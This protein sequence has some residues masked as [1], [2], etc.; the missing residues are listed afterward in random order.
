[1]EEFSKKAGFRRNLSIGWS[2]FWRLW[3]PL[4]TVQVVLVLTTES[5]ATIWIGIIV[6]VGI[7]LAEWAGKSVALTRYYAAIPSFIGWSIWWRG[8]VSSWILV[9]G[10]SLAN[11]IMSLT[12][13][14]WLF[15][16]LIFLC[17][18]PGSF[19]L[20]LLALGFMTNGFITNKISQQQ[21]TEKAEGIQ[22]EKK[23]KK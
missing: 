11:K 12:H 6:L 7:P 8:I 2:V 10:T 23:Q 20:Y 14:N 9:A 22:V 4:F 18:L 5:W 3:L 1:M 21:L 15:F 19:I 17:I 13:G 16:L